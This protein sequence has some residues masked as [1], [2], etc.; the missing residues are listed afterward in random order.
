MSVFNAASYDHHE[1][2][3]FRE[4]RH[5]GLRAII[6]VHNTQLG[7]AVGGLRMFPYTDDD[8]ALDDVLRLSRGMTYKSALAGLPMGGGK[9]VI[10][11]D[12][13]RDKTPALMQAMG[14][15]VDSLGGR[16]VTAED[17]GTTV[18]DMREI[19]RRTSYVSG[20]DERGGGDPSPY[21]AYGVYCG[22][23]AALRQRRGSETL[24]GLTVALQGAGAVGRHLAKRLLAAGARVF[25]ADVNRDNLERAVALGAEAVSPASILS[26]E[27]DVLAPCALGAVLDAHTVESLRADIIAGAANNQLASPA[28]AQ[29]LFERGILYVPDFV[30]NAGGII[31]VHYQRSAGRELQG[32]QLDAVCTEHIARIGAVLADIFARSAREQRDTNAIAEAMAEERFR[33]KPDQVA[34]KAS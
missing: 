27:V 20:H 26:M 1:L 34:R 15:F 29:R 2:V 23:L 6:A 21:T 30:L 17:S 10:I 28:Q 8:A 12:P 3:A 11:G 9:A 18:A 32:D 7:S 25:V 19:A 14:E 16:F 5:S 33:P 24:A 13:Q 22:I 31:A 4:D